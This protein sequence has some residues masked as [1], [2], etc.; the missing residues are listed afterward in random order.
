M[1]LSQYPF[2][3][4]LP[5]SFKPV[6]Y[7]LGVEFRAIVG[8][9]VLGWTVGHEEIREAVE[10]IIGVEPSLHHDGEALPTEFVDDRQDLEGP[11]IM[12]PVRYEIIGPDMVTMG[13]PEPD[14]SP[15][16]EPQPSAFGLL[17]GNLQPLLTPDAFH[18]LVIDPPTLSS[19]QGCDTAIPVTPV[20]FGKLNNFLSKSL[21]GICPLGYEPL[22]RPRPADHPASTPL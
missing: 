21:F 15:I 2:S 3:Q 5:G 19:E 16:V 17:L 6:P 12:C 8:S 1:K 20:P 10:H 13:G 22:G 18:P 11:S 9:D 4:G 7:R 14:T